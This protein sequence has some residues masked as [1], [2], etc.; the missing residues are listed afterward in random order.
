M[1]ALPKS[2]SKQP[3]QKQGPTKAF[4]G[5]RKQ[6]R[7]DTSTLSSHP[8]VSTATSHTLER[9]PDTRQQTGGSSRGEPGKQTKKFEMRHQNPLAQ[10]TRSIAEEASEDFT[11]I[12]EHLAK[13]NGRLASHGIQKGSAQKVRAMAAKAVNNSRDVTSVKQRAAAS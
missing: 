2:P 11:N 10:R 13:G 8:P 6:G 3:K 7:N 12:D 4:Q 5:L 9:K 1:S